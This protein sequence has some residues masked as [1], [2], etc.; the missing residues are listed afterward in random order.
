MSLIYVIDFAFKRP[1]NVIRIVLFQSECLDC[2]IAT[3]VWWR[4]EYL[5][6]EL[7]E[8]R[9]DLEV[10]SYNNKIVKT[11]YRNLFR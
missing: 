10:L 11:G 1:V 8:P 2:F 9:K 5:V 7:Y 6:Y 3:L 4:P